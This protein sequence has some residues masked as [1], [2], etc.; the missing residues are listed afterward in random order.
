MPFEHYITQGGKRLRC[1]YTTGTCAAL[2]AKAAARMLLTGVSVCAETVPTPKGLPVT[3]DIVNISMGASAVACAVKKDGGDDV[4]ATDGILIAAAVSKTSGGISID[5]GEGVGR[6]TLPG[7]DQPVGNAAINSTP[8]RMICQALLE[9][10]AQY[11]YDG[12]FSVV[13]SVPGGMDLAKK[14]FNPQLGITGGISILG[15]SGIVEPQSLRALLDSLAVEVRV[16]AARG[17]RRLILTP[18]NYGEHFLQKFP[19]LAAMPQVK[20]ANFIGDTLDL[21]AESGMETVLLVGHI[22][23]MVKLAGGIM[24][25][26]SRT[27]D[28][29]TELFAVYAAL[30]GAGQAEIQ[31]LMNAA[32]SDACIAI[33]DELGLRRPVLDALTDAAQSHLDRRA[34][35]AM[36]VGL[37]TFSNQYGLLT[38]SH[39]AEQILKEWGQTL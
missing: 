3:A 14:T 33:L 29:R 9:L 24:N 16:H 31:R 19:T 17:V 35:G 11:R 22:G 34:G 12:G 25:T 32:T 26:H 2:A 39:T 4:D 15:T 6:V 23:K 10:A 30:Q 37:V 5:G 28:C 38:I 21:A 27:A 13:I 20:C 1:G 36:R 18:G 8:R 7:L